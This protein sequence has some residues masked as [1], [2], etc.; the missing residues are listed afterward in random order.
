MNFVISQSGITTE[1]KWKCVCEKELCISLQQMQLIAFLQGYMVRNGNVFKRIEIYLL[2]FPHL[3]IT[4]Y[5]QRSALFF[6]PIEL[7]LTLFKS[8][9][10]MLCIPLSCRNHWYEFVTEFEW[11]P[12]LQIISLCSADLRNVSPGPW[13]ASNDV[14]FRNKCDEANSMHF[15]SN[16]SAACRSLGQSVFLYHCGY[17]HVTADSNGIGRDRTYFYK[18]QEKFFASVKAE[19]FRG[20]HECWGVCH[21]WI[22]SSKWISGPESSNLWT[23]NLKP[24]DSWI[25]KK[26][27]PK[28]Q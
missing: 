4:V 24:T 3:S 18:S 15:V 23:E 12:W 13:A 11:R 22:C 1:F 6:L 8:N 25:E 16:P 14:M 27:N 20:K 26:E 7:K 19:G 2:C 9:A 17:F 5:V 28:T 21:L 10:V